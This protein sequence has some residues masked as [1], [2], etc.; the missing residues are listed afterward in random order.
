MSNRIIRCKVENEFIRGAGGVIGAAGSHDDVELELS[1]S[2]VWEGTSK[3]IV[4]FD[5]LNEN[6]VV[7]VL[8]S[9]L[10]VPGED[11]LYRVPVPVEAKAVEGDMKITIRGANVADGVE[12]RAVVAATA[13][14]KV[15]PA[16]WDPLA[17]ESSEPS[18]SVTDQLQQEIEGVKSDLE[19]TAAE[20]VA[21]SDAKYI[22]LQGGGIVTDPYTLKALKISAP[23][24]MATGIGQTSEF[25]LGV[26]NGNL[27][28]IAYT[29]SQEG[30]Y[31][32]GVTIDG[33][34]VSILTRN[35]NPLSVNSRIKGVHDPELDSDAVNKKYVDDLKAAAEEQYFLWGKTTDGRA[36]I[37]AE[38]TD[39]EHHYIAIG[40]LSTHL[41]RDYGILGGSKLTVHGNQLC[42]SGSEGVEIHSRDKVIR[43]TGGVPSEGEDQPCRLQNVLAPVEDLDAANKKYVD[44]SKTQIQTQA[45]GRYLKLTGGMI[46]D[47]TNSDLAGSSVEIY[48]GS[49]GVE[50]VESSSGLVLRGTGIFPGRLSANIPEVGSVTVG[51]TA[52]GECGIEFQVGGNPLDLVP[53]FSAENSPVAL[54]IK[55]VMSYEV[56]A[57]IPL[58]GS[59]AKGTDLVSKAYVDNSI[60]AAIDDSWG[61]SY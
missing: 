35:G 48:P 19:D 27:R 2:P 4:W 1:F 46:K 36:I 28:L 20:I 57:S 53:E 32:G 24:I 43:L 39:G 9:N 44:D 49:I 3:K 54:H 30:R 23:N 38:D 42:L 51:Y 61:A 8:G 52:L 18:A 40:G 59:P 50:S 21:Q 10:L 58:S 5:A 55:D 26:D 6:P 60:K 41:Y 13:C 47:E 11:N 12:T 22:K 56:L 15:L 17:V 37:G 31:S 7:T 29:P 34:T 25:D 33:E 14:F 45:D 16:I